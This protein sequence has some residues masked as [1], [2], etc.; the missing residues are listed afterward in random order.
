MTEEKMYDNSPSSRTLFKTRTNNLR[1][2]DKEW[3]Y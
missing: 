2:N 1:I 3:I